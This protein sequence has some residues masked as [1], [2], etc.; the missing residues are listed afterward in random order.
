MRILAFCDRYL[1]GSKGGGAIRS[2]SN[3]VA[4]LPELEFYIV[5]RDRDFTETEAYA[6]IAAGT[7]NEVCGARVR[8]LRPG[9][10]T[11]GVLEAIGRDV[12][13]DVLY[14]N[15]FFSPEFTL[16]PLWMRRRGRLVPGRAV[17]APRG[18]LAPAAL[19]IKA[20]KK[21]VFLTVARAARLYEGVV[22]QASTEHEAAELR[23]FAG[24]DA[25][26]AVAPNVPSVPPPRASD[27]IDKRPGELRLVFVSRVSRKKNLDGAIRALRGVKG[28]VVF[29]VYG[30]LEDAAYWEEC[31]RAVETLPEGIE[32]RHRGSLPHGEV[33][34]V[35]GGYH[36]FFMPTHGENFGHAIWEAMAAGLPVVI[37]DKTAWRALAEAG[38]GWDLPEGDEM[39]L[40]GAIQQLVEMDQEALGAL[41]RGAHALAHRFSADPAVLEANR[42]LFAG[43]G[44]K[45]L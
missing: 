44:P 9:E 31:L 39:G 45:Q 6:D 18:E 14:L 20:A 19:A 38:A 40:A 25:E 23:A 43:S 7:W 24:P 15:S 2:V 36:A 17:L 16:R 26:V 33:F 42:A 1:P 10:G 30:P 11:P 3:L 28:R 22:W 37:S 4:A 5:T 29:D 27:A 32:V 35:L 21:R 12:R 41:S 8:Y 34:A 13:P